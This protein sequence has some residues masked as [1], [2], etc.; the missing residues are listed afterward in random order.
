MTVKEL[1]KILYVEDDPSIQAIAT[2][3]LINIGGF[4]IK[5]CYS[6]KEALEVIDDFQP[7]FILSD[8]M[9]PEVDGPTMLKTLRSNSKYDDIPLVFISARAQKHEI[10]EY[11]RIGATEVI[12]KPFDPIALPDD[13]REIWKRI[14]TDK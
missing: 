12:S 11:I 5:A 8:V 14:N 2:I 9:M 4:E 10:E 6:G 13:L 3:S 1:K 7:D